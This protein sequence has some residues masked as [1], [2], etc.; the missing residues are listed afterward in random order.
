MDSKV[1]APLAFLRDLKIY[2]VEKPYHLTLTKDRESDSV[3]T[4]IAHD[5]YDNVEVTD[6]RGSEGLFHL[7][8]HGFQLARHEISMA[9]NDFASP[10]TRDQYASEMQSFLNA[11]LGAQ[12]VRLMHYK[13]RDRNLSAE[14]G[15]E[16]E[17]NIRGWPIPGVHIDASAEG[18]LRRIKLNWPLELE[19]LQ[20]RRV[21]IL[22]V[23]RPL[24]SPLRS[25]PMAFCDV[26]SLDPEDMVLA[27]QISPGF[28]GENTLVYFNP[29]QRFY[30]V[31][32]QQQSEVWI[33]KQFD[34]QS[35]V[36]GAKSPSLPSPPPE[37]IELS[38][39]ALS[40]ALEEEREKANM[41][42]LEKAT[43]NLDIA[44]NSEKGNPVLFKTYL[45][46]TTSRDIANLAVA[47]EL[48]ST[49]IELR[50]GLS[51]IT[52]VNTPDNVRTYGFVLASP[53]FQD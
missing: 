44:G 23:W 28:Q 48:R 14:P 8:I 35:D 47:N 31:S 17:D 45:I 10:E 5:V 37:D 40:K 38:W 6:I 3:I 34:S 16:K 1:Y 42:E 11:F 15:V 9:K 20:K 21:Q 12:D 29:K 53:Q 43:E 7:D 19:E 2:E 25:W 52:N 30:Y 27:D 24:K 39:E 41:E 18:A 50:A 33:F 46:S 49:E 13:V 26:R 22:N 36:A 51:M 4:N 32:E